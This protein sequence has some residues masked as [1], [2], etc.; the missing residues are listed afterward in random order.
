MKTPEMQVADYLTNDERLVTM[1]DELRQDKLSYVPIFTSTP[2]DP[3]IKASSAPW[4]RITPIPGDDAIYSDDVRFFEYPRVQVDFWIREEND[5]RLMDIQER[6]YETLH[7]NGFERYYKNSYPDPDLDN[8][9]MV[10]AN[11]E[12]FEERNDI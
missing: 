10:T 1:M 7:S 12:G 4:I 5:D 11:F 3:F 2:D 8:C 9:I 6:I